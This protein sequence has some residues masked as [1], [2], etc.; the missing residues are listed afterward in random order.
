VAQAR[1]QIIAEVAPLQIEGE[2]AT[3]SWIRA[4]DILLRAKARRD[5]RL[6]QEA[7]KVLEQENG[8]GSDA[9]APTPP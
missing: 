1:V 5:A 4:T 7:R 2:Q 9:D 6:F 3:Q 8:S